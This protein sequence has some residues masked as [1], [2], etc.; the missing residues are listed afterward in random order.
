MDDFARRIMRYRRLS[1]MHRHATAITLAVF[2]V[3]L[4]IAAG[5]L[6]LTM[7]AVPRIVGV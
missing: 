3:F 7:Y 1:F 4:A 2:A 6:L 5:C